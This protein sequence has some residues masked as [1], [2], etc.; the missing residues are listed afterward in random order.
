M[1]TAIS[2]ILNRIVNLIIWV[3]VFIL[4]QVFDWSYSSKVRILLQE[5]IYA[6]DLVILIIWSCPNVL[7]TFPWKIHD[8][9]VSILVSII[10]NLI[11]DWIN[12]IWVYGAIWTFNYILIIKVLP[13]F[14]VYLKLVK[15]CPSFNRGLLERRTQIKLLSFFHWCHICG[16]IL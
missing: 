1:S 14:Q 9:D 6:N 5:F 16:F 2:L 7:L 4:R 10:C 8:A 12:F 3:D 13:E 15:G 11:Q